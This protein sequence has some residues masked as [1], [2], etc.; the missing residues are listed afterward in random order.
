MVHSCGCEDQKSTIRRTRSTFL[1][2]LKILPSTRDCKKV[3]CLNFPFQRATMDEKGSAQKIEEKR[4]AGVEFEEYKVSIKQRKET[5]AASASLPTIFDANNV[6][7]LTVYYRDTILAFRVRKVNQCHTI[8]HI[9]RTMEAQAL[10][11]EV[12]PG[13]DVLGKKNP[14]FSRPFG[15]GAKMKLVNNMLMGRFLLSKT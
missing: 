2:V 8:I 6:S 5:Y 7:R 14:Y 4:S 11:K 12:K 13:F 9:Y 3:S 10:Y 15:N 1:F